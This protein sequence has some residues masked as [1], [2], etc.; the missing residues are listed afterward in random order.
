MKFG[1][2]FQEALKRD[3]F[4]QHWVKS[5]IAY[6]QLKKCIKKV[7]G[8]LSS[9]GLDAQTLKQLLQAVENG[10]SLTHAPFQYS[11]AGLAPHAT[12]YPS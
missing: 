10:S 11:F 4:P 5:A 1:H 9:L 3:D 7:Q 12:W 6:G 2:Q 8:E